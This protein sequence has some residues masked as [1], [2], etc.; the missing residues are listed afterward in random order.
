[1][2]NARVITV[3]IDGSE[4]SATALA[5]AA[6]EA[7]RRGALLR[8]VHAY[9]IPVYGDFGAGMALPA[10]DLSAYDDSQKT[11]AAEQIAPVRAQF[12]NVEIELKVEV[13]AP[14]STVIDC[15]K[16]A[17]LVVI[18][19]RGKGALAG[20]V[21]GSVAHAV[22]RRAPCAVVLIPHN[23]PVPDVKR[24]VVGTDGS[25]AAEAAVEWAR[26]EAKLWDVDLTVV[27]AW[28]YPY[29]GA[30][31]GVVQPSELMELDAAR[32]LAHSA[33][34]VD[35]HRDRPRYIHTELMQ[36]SASAALV[37]EAGVGDILVVGAKGRGALRS[38]LLGS[39]SSYVIH[40]ATCPVAV[41]H[42]PFS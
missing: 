36:G 29:L 10:M 25:D 13:G 17:E 23:E 32:V 16:D 12:P 40:H 41:I 39:T 15:S 37:E 26:A 3:G 38:A 31:S 11:G 21:T 2:T 9:S 4:S 35:Q 19:S 6:R 8:V 30:R 5:W 14:I 24:I 7:N 33:K 18:G 20:L 34:L 22:A 28:E 1:M 27:H 42:A